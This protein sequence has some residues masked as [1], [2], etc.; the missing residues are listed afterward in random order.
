[1]AKKKSAVMAGSLD[2]RTSLFLIVILN[3]VLCGFYYAFAGMEAMKFSALSAAFVISYT[4]CA[5]SGIPYASAAKT[6]SA[7][8]RTDYRTA[9]YIRR[10]SAVISF[11]AAGI[12]ALILIAA[13]RPLSALI[14]GPQAP[15]ADIRMLY[16]LMILSAFYAL[17]TCGLM[18]LRGFYQGTGEGE[19]DRISQLIFVG[20]SYIS[21]ILISVILVFGFHLN[22]TTA[23]YG[24]IGGLITGR[25]LSLGY[26]ILFDRMKYRKY[27]A[28]ARVQMIPAMQKKNV[29]SSLLGFAAPSLFLAICAALFVLS[30]PVLCI[31][32]A[33]ISGMNYLDASALTGKA[34]WMIPVICA[35][36][37]LCAYQ[38]FGK[39]IRMLSSKKT[40]RAKKS[41]LIERM[42]IG[43]MSMA[44]AV[45]FIYGCLSEQLIL[46]FYGSE[47][48][49]NTVLLMRI[50]SAESLLAGLAW[51]MSGTM[52]VLGFGRRSASYAFI[53]LIC[54]IVLIIVLPMRF[55]PESMM[56]SGI[57]CLVIYLFL[58]FSKISNRYA[59]NYA[60][61]CVACFRIL[62]AC[63]AMNG[64]F[65]LFKFAGFGG[66]GRDMLINGLLILAMII[67]A[68]AVYAFILDLSGIRMPL[69][70]R[71]GK[72]K[73]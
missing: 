44:L 70:H 64:V 13:G 4:L 67:T 39:E 2:H 3:I 1:M 68:L 54:R 23:V 47:T 66:L 73:K 14:L 51:M 72:K 24:L 71:K 59:L 19:V 33:E 31:R 45:C 50:L 29:F 16:I 36:P 57:G 37:L 15:E 43:Y 52:T 7:V 21:A 9:L 11:F 42:L 32:T 17:V 61:V 26:Y 55:S 28:M 63:L 25:A 12:Y 46:L 20:G 60:K 48:G 65:A 62:L 35:L 49:L 5:S 34:G 18:W 8:S 38:V 69:F 56:Y 10:A 41:A 30:L 53:A 27:R 22:R 6:A 58:C 40:D